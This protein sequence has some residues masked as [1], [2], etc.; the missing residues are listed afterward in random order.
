[1]G[2]R[3]VDENTVANIARILSGNCDVIDSGTD[4]SDQ[5]ELLLEMDAQGLLNAHFAPGT[6]W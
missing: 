6:V 2:V 4:S 1:M 3:F 5:S